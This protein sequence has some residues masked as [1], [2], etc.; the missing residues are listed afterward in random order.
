MVLICI[1][2]RF[3][4]HLSAL[5]PASRGEQ[6]LR[7]GQDK[8]VPLIHSACTTVCN[9]IMQAVGNAQ[10]AHPAPLTYHHASALVTTCS[11]LG[12][13]PVESIQSFDSTTAP[14]GCVQ[15]YFR[16]VTPED[17]QAL[18][19]SHLL[20]DSD[21]ALRVPFLGREPVP[22]I[23]LRVMQGALTGGD[24]H[25]GPSGAGRSEVCATRSIN[26]LMRWSSWDL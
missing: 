10:L 1:A 26:A 22:N 7:K 14:L 17:L 12:L 16:D 8:E 18:L 21:P 2:S 25:A 20:P 5:V 6:R 4:L 24:N 15:S 11:G 19:P 23:D 3:L 13:L 9:S